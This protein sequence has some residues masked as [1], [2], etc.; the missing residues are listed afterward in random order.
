LEDLQRETR[1][2]TWW[3]LQQLCNIFHFLS[4]FF[5]FLSLNRGNSCET[6]NT[7]LDF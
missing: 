5:H 6:R 1:R 2:E 4:F 3:N 7:C